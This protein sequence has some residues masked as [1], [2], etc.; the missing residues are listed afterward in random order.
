MPLQAIRIHPRQK[1]TFAVPPSPSRLLNSRSPV[2]RQ[3]RLIATERV[4]LSQ[5][6]VG[7]RY[8][9]RIPARVDDFVPLLHEEDNRPRDNPELEDDDSPPD[10]TVHAESVDPVRRVYCD[11]PLGDDE[12]E[13][14]GAVVVEF[15]DV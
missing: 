14:Y 8:K 9:R 10:E 12:A 11:G 1:I 13:A 2:L 3:R 15:A 7:R 6:R 5:R 4:A